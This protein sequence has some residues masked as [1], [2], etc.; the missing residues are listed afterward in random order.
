M[1]VG[2]AGARWVESTSTSSASKSAHRRRTV[3]RESRRRRGPRDGGR[4]LELCRKVRLVIE[5]EQCFPLARTIACVFSNG[6][7]RGQ[8]LLSIELFS[9]RSSETWGL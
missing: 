5:S 2:D 1:R 6:A 8:E 7:F 3:C 4:W 9:E